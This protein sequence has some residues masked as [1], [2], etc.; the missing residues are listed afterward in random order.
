MMKRYTVVIVIFLIYYILSSTTS[1]DENDCL[2]VKQM[3]N[4]LCLN[5]ALESVQ[6]NII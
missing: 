5:V 2:T 4:N 6:H 3:I 1:L